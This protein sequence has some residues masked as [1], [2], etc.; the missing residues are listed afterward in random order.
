MSSLT[1]TATPR[2]SAP[3]AVV[4]AALL[5]A[6]S[7]PSW[8]SYYEVEWDLPARVDRPARAG[9]RRTVCSR[10]GRVCCRERIVE[11]VPD[12]RFSYEQAAGPFES[13]RGSVD[14]ARVSDGGT[15]VTW[16]AIYRH[17]LP[18][19]NTVRRQRLQ[20]LVHD[21]ASYAN[22]IVSRHS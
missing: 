15:D 8:S 3:A 7:W 1:V 22:S 9:D 10:V 13:H 21:L 4:Y 17:A 6:E 18:L 14:L 16:S 2:S 11:L 20:I 5:D 19:L 12:W